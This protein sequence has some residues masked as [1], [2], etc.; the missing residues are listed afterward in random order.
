MSLAFVFPGQ[1]SQSVGMLSALAEHYPI[2]KA[3]FTEASDALGYPLWDL[4]QTGPETELNKTAKTQP[5]LLAAGVSVWRV[6]N[7]QCNYVPKLMA[8]HS[9]GEYTALVCAGALSFP[10]AV[11]LV[12]DR[13]EYMQ[14][15]VPEGTGS[16]A[17]I[18]GLENKQVEMVC[19]QSARG[20]IVSAANYNST[21]QVVIAGHTEA[22]ER[23]VAAAKEAGARRSVILP[24]SIPSHCELMHAAAQRLATRL[25]GIN[26]QP[27]GIPV[28]HNVDVQS[29][30]DPE[31]I[32]SALVEQLSQP[33]RWVETIQYMIADNITQVV[34]CGPGKILS[35]L[36]K[37]IDRNIQTL[38]VYDPDSLEN[39]L[40]ELAD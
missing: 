9:L 12:A 40:T 39:A 15:A 31:A 37:R 11:K 3:T 20:Q 13:G 27:P 32:S 35:G 26:L 38:P 29:R 14:L 17:A 28:I 8:G 18:L 10:E 33:V 19:E 23:A 7:D 21:G 36:I 22:V 1:G 24:V 25:Q 34:E 30:T 16:M 2:I 5:A 6:W 4:V